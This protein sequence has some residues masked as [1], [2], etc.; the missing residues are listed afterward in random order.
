MTSKESLLKQRKKNSEAQ[1]IAQNRP[2]VKAKTSGKNHYAYNRDSKWK[3]GTSTLDIHNWLRK[4]F[5]KP[6]KCENPNCKHKSQKYEWSLLKGCQYERKRKN[7]WMLCA[8]CHHVYDDKAQNLA[9]AREK[10]W[11]KNLTKDTDARIK[12]Y[13]IKSGNSRKNKG[14]IPKTA[15]KKGQKPW[16]FGLTKETDER[17]KKL[18]E[19]ESITK[20]KKKLCS[21]Q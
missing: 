13:G 3:T 2:E 18:G 8:S 6:N 12:K 17:L 9:K 14:Y 10:P 4:K 15:F 7:F 20:Q 5:G 21:T 1:K 19:H 11:N 16:N